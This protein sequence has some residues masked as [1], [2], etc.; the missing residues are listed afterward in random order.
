MDQTQS[1]S[2]SSQNLP[3]RRR[4][5]LLLL[6]VISVPAAV[7]AY[8]GATRSP[9]SLTAGDSIASLRV[10]ALNGTPL[11]VPAQTA[12]DKPHVWLIVS[13]SCP[14]CR[15]EL[16]EMQRSSEP[17]SRV[18]IV[19]LSTP[20][21]TRDFMSAFPRLQQQTV[22]DADNVLQRTY[23]DFRTPTGLLMDHR[24]VLVQKW[25]GPRPSNVS[26]VFAQ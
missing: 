8:V 22:I 19:S 2:V 14:I 18:T 9:E 20:G 3:S 10:R 16:E 4:A 6:L 17:F 26:H 25:R 7:I 21:Q 13:A 23:G 1:S 5:I 15:V 24:G 11:E 12:D